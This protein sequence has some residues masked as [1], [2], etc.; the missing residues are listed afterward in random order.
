MLNLLFGSV[1]HILV[2]VVIVIFG[3]AYLATRRT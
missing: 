2:V 3:V 1:L